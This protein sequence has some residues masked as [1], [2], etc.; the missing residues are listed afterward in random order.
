VPL[1]AAFL[2]LAD[3]GT[4]P[5]R[6]RRSPAAAATALVLAFALALLVSGAGAV[7]GTWDDRTAATLPAKTWPADAEE[8]DAG[9]GA[10]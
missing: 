6:P 5:A 3:P 2:A 8:D 9:P 1:A 4:V 7:L 10:G